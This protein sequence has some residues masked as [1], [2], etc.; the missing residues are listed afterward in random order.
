MT[1]V[2]ERQSR[3]QAELAETNYRTALL[4]LQR[5]LNLSGEESL[6]LDAHLAA[7]EWL[8]VPGSEAKE[9]EHL[10]TADCR[11]S[12]ATL[13]MGR[14][15]VMAGAA[16][17]DMAR[18]SAGLA[19]ANRVQNLAVGPIYERDESGTTLFGLRAQT[20][21]PVW[22]SGRALANQRQAELNQSLTNLEQLRERAV[23]E[24]Q[25]ASERYELARRLAGQEYAE[26]TKTVPDDLRKIKEQFDAGQVDIL[27]V[28]AAQNSLL[29]EERTYLDLLNEVAQ[30]A[31]D[32]TQMTGLPPARIVTV[33]DGSPHSPEQI[34]APP[35]VSPALKP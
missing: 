18:A 11:E 26:F 20:N 22:D 28:F 30:A 16:G 31:A 2:A 17:S 34:P 13:A 12:V 19:R 5:Q 1:R 3:K 10:L 7:F 6:Q 9:G 35:P 14:P 29:Q 23:V 15:D 24:A 4:V 33:R 27:N 8:P 25:T 32:V 21:L